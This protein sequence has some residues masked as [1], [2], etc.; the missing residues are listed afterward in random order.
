MK[1][2]NLTKDRVVTFFFLLFCVAILGLSIRGIAGNPTS[3]EL[4]S[5]K[6]KENGPFELSPERGRFALIYSVAEDRSLQFSKSIADFTMPDLAVSEDGQYVSMFSPGVSFLALPGYMIGKYFGVSQAGAFAVISLFALFNIILV[7]LIAIRLGAVPFAANLG[8]FAFAFATPAFAYAVTLYQHHISTFLMLLCVYIILRW[9]NWWSLASIWFIIALSV[10]VDNPNAFLM[11]PVGLYALGGIIS[12]ET[13]QK[14][15]EIYLR[16]ARLLTFAAIAVPF[17]FLF[18][19]NLASHGD[20]FKLSGTLRSAS[21]FEEKNK[22]AENVPDIPD[23]SAKK[24]TQFG[25]ISWFK[26][27][28][29]EN[30]SKTSAVTGQ[31]QEDKVNDSSASVSKSSI[32]DLAANPQNEK[33]VLNFFKTRNLSNGFYTHIFSPDRGVVYF[34]PLVLL[35]ILGLA[36]LYG[37]NNYALNLIVAIIG[38]NLLVYSMW[39]DPYGGWAF[40]SRYLI[41]AYALLSLGL[42]MGLSKWRKNYVFLAIFLIFFS[43]SAWVNTLGALTSSTNPPRIEILALENITGKEEKYTFERNWQYLLSNGS[44]SFVF[45]SVF[46]GKLSGEKYFEAI[47]GFIIALA[48]S[49]VLGL[50]SPKQK[51]RNLAN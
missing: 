30:L 39:G 34:T 4:N 6:W 50:V 23:D 13:K 1:I 31:V 16:T 14:G 46:R 2:S 43:Y 20:P 45:N 18:W 10:V 38:I 5:S 32:D 25:F 7:R 47:I 35:G 11:F 28:S 27:L 19:F 24:N 40:G 51:T 9:K 49:M 44:K 36:L 22:E 29:Q 41:P 12:F 17:V 15:V 3:K 37:K 8:A 26:Q 48:F 42:A 21:A 33:S